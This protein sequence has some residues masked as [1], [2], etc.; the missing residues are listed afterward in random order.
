MTLSPTLGACVTRLLAIVLV[1]LALAPTAHASSV[2]DAKREINRLFRHDA[3]W[4]RCVVARESG[5]NPRAVNWADR[6]ANGRG[7]FGLFQLGRIHVGMVG[8][9]WRRLLDPVTNVRVAYRLYSR[10]GKR[11]WAGGRWSC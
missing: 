6:H 11:P 1:L 10:S 9:D 3:A 2:Q 4:A 7:S 5:W 8:G